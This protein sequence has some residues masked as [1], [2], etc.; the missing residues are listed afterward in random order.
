VH[1]KTVL[2]DTDR[3]AFPSDSSRRSIDESADSGTNRSRYSLTP[4]LTAEQV[5]LGRATF[6]REWPVAATPGFEA[7]QALRLPVAR[8]TTAAALPGLGDADRDRVGD[9]V[10]D[11]IDALAPVIG[12]W[13]GPLGFSRTRRR[14]Q[15][16]SRAL[17]TAL[18]ELGV[19]DPPQVST[20]LAAGIQVPIAAGSWLLVELAS[21]PSV[22]EELRA[23]PDLLAPVV[24]ETLRLCSPTWITGRVARSDV[25]LGPALVEQGSV[26]MVSPL[27]L[28]RDP[29]L[30]PG[31][32]AGQPPL[33][34]FC[35]RRWLQDVRPG[36]WLPFGAGPHAC[37]GR[38]L[39]LA[40][41]TLLTEWASR[42]SLA[43]LEPS[44]V[45]QDR[46]IFPQPARIQ[47]AAW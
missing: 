34:E 21:T 47:F 18:A 36:A 7:M 2:G 27:L 3:F 1:A 42:H 14:E 5:A 6:A 29:D 24:W 37:P 12:S 23:D 33:D 46:G 41:L 22:H 43:L 32:A 28:G 20:M 44:R 4:A 9:L 13:F 25:H 16:A 40:Q 39:G 10:L 38:N 26:V 45:N 19:P 15:R 11:W 35:P 17:N 8:S 30:A 31:P